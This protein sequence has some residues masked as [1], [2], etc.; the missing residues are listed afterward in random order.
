MAISIIRTLIIFGAII[1]SFRVMGKRQLGQLEPAEL[2]VSI[3]IADL[4]SHPLQDVGTPLLYGLI[5][6]LTLLCS[7]IIISGVLLKSIKLRAV[8]SGSPSVIIENGKLIQ[9]QMSKN[10][11]TIDEV[12]EELRK[13]E[14]LDIASVQFGIIETDG[15]LSVILY[16]EKSSVTPEQLNIQ[17]HTVEYPEIVIND[18][19]ICDKAIKKLGRDRRWL[20]KELKKHKVTDPKQVFLMSADRSGCVYF[21]GREQ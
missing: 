6:V 4:A 2:A 3:L 14:I 5:P 21:D 20:D 13:K 1:V 16:P 18:G 11:I 8:L 12:Y 17:A 19:R 9:K 7:Q 15:S 10:R